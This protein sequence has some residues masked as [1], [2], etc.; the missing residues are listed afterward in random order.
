M[1]LSI[2]LC[3]LTKYR[4]DSFKNLDSIKYLTDFCN[5]FTQFG[6]GSEQGWITIQATLVR[7][8]Y[9]FH[10]LK[11]VCGILSHTIPIKHIKVAGC[12]WQNVKKVKEYE[13]FCKTLY[14]DGD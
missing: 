10:I 14:L 7:F 8:L 13:Y 9:L 11:S 6:V 5:F 2:S 1:I 12:L 3:S 4:L